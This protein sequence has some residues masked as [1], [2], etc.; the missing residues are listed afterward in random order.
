MS[1]KFRVLHDLWIAFDGGYAGIP[2]DTR[3]IFDVLAK[4]DV[5][6]VDGLFYTR[7]KNFFRKQQK[8]ARFL[9]PD[10]IAIA[11]SRYFHDAIEDLGREKL[12]LM[13]KIG[14]MINAEIT[15]NYLK[16]KYALYPVDN[17]H[18]EMLWRSAF[19]RTLG[20][21]DREHVLGRDFYYSDISWR[22]ILYAGYFNRKVYL[23]TQP[24]DYILFPD[25][26][27]VSVS[28]NTKKIVRY[29]DSFAF[30]CPD[31]FQTYHATMHL[32]SLKAC[33]K[34][35]Y[36]VCNSGPTRDTLLSVF[37]EIEKKSFVI[38]PVVR[39]YAKAKDWRVFQQVC[40]T[41]MARKLY[42]DLNFTN[43]LSLFENDQPFEYIL[44]LSTLEPRKNYINLIRAWE[45]LFY[46]YH[47]KMKLIIVANPGWLS[48]EIEA[49]MRPHVEM[50]NIIHLNN[51]SSDE[52]PYLFSHAKLFA[53][54]SYIEGFGSPPVEAMQCECPV[55][56]SDN[57]THR[58][59]MGDAALFVNPYDIDS[60][61]EGMAK[62]IIHND[63]EQLR[64]TLI[65]NALVRVKNYS[66]DNVK[67]QW[68]DLFCGLSG[69]EA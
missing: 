23:N 54:L 53:S 44:A 38:P 22:D 39:P 49:V 57:P 32:N 8:P 43:T 61:T 13:N 52:M 24:Y 16:R 37:P 60:I 69:F 35:S 5:L 68:M 67:N 15:N 63:A 36:F 30:L 10:E 59:S 12:S 20:P 34:D 11:S 66:V 42:P 50:G 46:R 9:S 65:H 26:R 7:R 14:L 48:D 2:Q 33:V 21:E 31:F 28:P 55:L 18:K 3:L 17:S 29:H 64:Q 1:N 27:P 4:N 6:N 45:N 58:W 56:A 25:V 51:V 62:L 19:S 41:R 47:H 40:L